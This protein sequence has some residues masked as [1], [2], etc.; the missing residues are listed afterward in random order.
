MKQSRNLLVEDLGNQTEYLTK[1]HN[2]HHEEILGKLSIIAEGRSVSPYLEPYPGLDN[3]SRQSP[4]N[5]LGDLGSADRCA[6]RLGQLIHDIVQ[7]DDFVV[8][9]EHL[10]VKPDAI[11]DV[12]EAG[13]TPLHIAARNGNLNIVRYLI[14]KG[15]NKN[16]DN[17]KDQ[18]PLHLAVQAGHTSLVRLLLA[19]GADSD[20]EDNKGHRPLFYAEK[21]SEMQWVLTVGPGLEER[22]SRGFTALR[23]F[24][25]RGDL[26]T[27]QSLLDA[28]ANINA[29]WGQ[30]NNT[31]IFEAAKGRSMEMLELLLTRGADIEARDTQDRTVLSQAAF[32]GDTLAVTK[33]LDHKAD[34]GAMNS[35]GYTPLHQACFY[36]R[37]DAAVELINRDPNLDLSTRGE[38]YTALCLA[39][40]QGATL[41]AQHLLDHGADIQK[42]HCG[43]TPLHEASEHGHADIVHLLLSR[44]AKHGAKNNDG[45]TSLTLAARQGHVD[46]ADEL[47]GFGKADVNAPGI[48]G[49]TALE[50]ASLHGRLEFV[51]LLLGKGAIVDT[52][53][54]GGGSAIA[55]AINCGHEEI[56][57]LLRMHSSLQS[58]MKLLE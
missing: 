8:L 50:E 36:L 13:E 30:D 24:V 6:T 58:E 18:T 35:K 54:S 7:R 12:N 57:E 49:W 2:A 23:A 41:I 38:G 42:G 4:R 19:K 16:A 5:S 47:L 3:Q 46:V 9:Q 31:P 22:D 48:N 20:T 51:K 45:Y 26:E 44:G 33:L 43:W 21:D 55:H 29:Q 15:A 39:S 32:Q 25:Q 34:I 52:F 27:V 56:L 28:G 10:K 11:F 17:P 37:T 53:D 1:F 14:R 40:M